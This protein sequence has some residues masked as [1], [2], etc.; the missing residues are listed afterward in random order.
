MT[1]LGTNRLNGA[2]YVSDWVAQG[3][4]KYR[5][6]EGDS[7]K[8]TIAKIHQELEELCSNKTR[9]SGSRVFT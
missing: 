2:S 5:A 1:R 4:W 7:S 9:E 8:G 3:A 6:R